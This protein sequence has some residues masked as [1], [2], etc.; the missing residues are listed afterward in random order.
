VSVI[1]TAHDVADAR[2]HRTV[3]ALRAAGLTVEVFGRGAVPDGPPGAKVRIVPTNGLAG[4]LL[5]SVRVPF[6][7]R[8]RLL[9][10]IDPDPLL[11]TTIRRM[12]RGTPFVA[13]CH[14]DYA[15][16]LRD[17]AWA[18]GW[19]GA[20]ARQVA[21]LSVR[22]AARAN[23]TTVADDH[24]PPLTARQRLV[25]RNLPSGGYLPPPS[26]PEPTPR[27]LYVGDVRRSRGLQTMLEAIESA[28]QW[29]LDVVGPVSDADQDWL[30]EW[31]ASSPAAT[32][33][34]LH[35]RKP[36]AQAWALARGAWVGLCLLEMTPAFVEAMPSK[37][38]EYL[39]CGLPVLVTPLPKAVQAVREA[40]AGQVVVDA[41]AAALALREYELRPELLREQRDAALA[42]ADGQAAAG[43]AYA[44]LAGRVGSLLEGLR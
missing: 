41:A 40:G 1:G 8:G 11:G 14:E 22:L 12:V 19:K 27:A 5:D 43:A 38:Y 24:V 2:T 17:R 13:D 37:V 15:A 31:L 6:R 4:R 42:W 36:P 26:E 25:V 39:A 21:G 30:A 3:D 18:T 34:T 23:L 33:V 7:A 32:R 29:R 10:V 35:G 44:D 28:P 9:L 20:A 16:L